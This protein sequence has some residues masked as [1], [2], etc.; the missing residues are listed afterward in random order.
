MNAII[1]NTR[2]QGCRQFSTPDPTGIRVVGERDGAA[3]RQAGAELRAQQGPQIEAAL[4]AGR[5]RPGPR[6][7][8]MVRVQEDRERFA[9]RRTVHW[10]SA[11]VWIVGRAKKVRAVAAGTL[12]TAARPAWP[13]ASFPRGDSGARRS[14]DLSEG[15]AARRQQ[16]LAPSV[17]LGRSTGARSPTGGRAVA[18]S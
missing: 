13:P 10:I 9:R 14:G 18:G 7:Q 11:A 2:M 15:G 1:E 12:P 8:G 4:Q 16:P 3:G 5:T 17:A 6:P